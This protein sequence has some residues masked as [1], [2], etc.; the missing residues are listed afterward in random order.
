[1]E[2]RKKL[3]QHRD[4]KEDDANDPMAY[5]WSFE[6]VALLSATYQE[7]VTRDSRL[8]FVWH[9]ISYMLAYQCTPVYLLIMSVNFCVSIFAN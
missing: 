6:H 2:K 9:T 8:T 1:M 7:L 4:N 5:C 3:P